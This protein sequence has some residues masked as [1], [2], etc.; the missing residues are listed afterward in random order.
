MKRYKENRIFI[1]GLV[2]VLFIQ[3]AYLSIASMNVPLMD[4]WH[5]INMFV[6]KMFSVGLSITDI[7]V[8]DGVHRSPL[9]FVYFI[10]NVKLFHLNARVEVY[11]GAILMTL[12]IVILYRVLKKDLRIKDSKLYGIAGIVL[13]VIVFNLNQFELISEQFALTFATRQILFLGSFILTNNYL[14]NIDKAKKYTFEL[15]MF[16]I[17]V[18]ELVGGGYFPAYVASIAFAIILHYFLS[19]KSDKNIYIKYY[20]LLLISLSVGTLIYLNGVLGDFSVASTES[21][22]IFDFI[23][24]YF[25]GVFLMLGVSI[26]GFTYTETITLLVG[27]LIF[28]FYLYLTIIFFKRLYFRRTYLPIALMGY[29]FCAMGII[30]LGRVDKYGIDFAFFSR[31]VC[32]SNFA[33]LGAIWIVF[34]CIADYKQENSND[35]KKIIQKVILLIGAVMI[36]IGIVSSDYKE[37]KM[38]SSRKE[39]GKNLIEDIYRIDQL[40]DEDIEHFQSQRDFVVNGV[41]I[42]KK[43]KLGVFQ[44]Q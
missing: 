1:W 16:Y 11:L 28:L 14:Q 31:Y 36:V 17:I 39:Y 9:Q 40:S 38:A 4:Y 8:N 23:K 41:D 21:I 6:E 30:Y 24:D 33:A 13:A 12:S 22:G 7:W 27:S 35:N 42:M 43:Y 19:I 18:I 26:I 37:L 25:I 10:L 15:G 34:M 2:I 3:L 5:Y 44:Y 29:T 20:I 32:E